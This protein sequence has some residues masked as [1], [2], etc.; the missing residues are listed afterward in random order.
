MTTTVATSCKR[1]RPASALGADRADVPQPHRRSPRPTPASPARRTPSSSSSQL[2]GGNDGLNTVIPF[3]DAEYAKLP[4]DAQACR[5]TRS[6]SSTTS[7][8]CTRRWTGW[9]GCCE[10]KALCVVQGVGYPNPSQSHFRSMDIWQ[11]AS[12]GRDADRG[13]DRQGAEGDAGR[14]RSTSRPATRPPRWPSTARRCGCR[15]SRRS[16]T[17]SCK[18]AAASGADKPQQATSSRARPSRGAGKP[19]ACSTSCRARAS[20]T[21]ASSQQLAGDRQELPAEGALP[22]DRRWPTG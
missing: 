16:R 18:L 21:Y 20:N 17:S 10:D 14:R 4:A 2:T 1:R 7:S 8:A 12:T 19:R 5:P 3:K 9:P 22:A 6:R 11:A 15:R 13:L